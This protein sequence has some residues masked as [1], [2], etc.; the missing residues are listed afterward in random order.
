MFSFTDVQHYV[1]ADI[2]D[3]SDKVQNYAD[4]VY[5]WILRRKYI[6]Y[7]VEKFLFYLLEGTKNFLTARFG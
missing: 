3:G 4:V 2:V 1:Y 5:G 6:V 7:P